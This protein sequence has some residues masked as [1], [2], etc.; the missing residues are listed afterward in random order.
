MGQTFSSFKAWMGHYDLVAARSVYEAEMENSEGSDL[1]DSLNT[2]TT[3]LEDMSA[4]S[5]SEKIR[6]N[7]DKIA[8]SQALV[9]NFKDLS[10]CSKLE[11]LENL[12]QKISPRPGSNG[13]TRKPQKSTILKKIIQFST[14]ID[15]LRF[16]K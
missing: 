6:N 15:K 9:R 5:E 1:N 2:S 13:N 12:A 10:S 14:N 16:T 7:E 4:L 8:L 3:T 11:I